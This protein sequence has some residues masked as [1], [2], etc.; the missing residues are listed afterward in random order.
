[1]AD[2]LNRITKMP[3]EIWTVKLADRITNLQ[4]P[5]V[6]WN[7]ERKMDYREEARLILNELKEGNEF[8]AR[9]LETKIEE[10]QI[11]IDN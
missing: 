3:I 5:P 11:Y 9:R 1:M 4:P 10:Y 8:L 7:N 6:H 2:S